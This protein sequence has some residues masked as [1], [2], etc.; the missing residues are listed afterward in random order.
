MNAAASGLDRNRSARIWHRLAAE[1]ESIDPQ[2]RTSMRLPEKQPLTLSQVPTSHLRHLAAASGLDSVGADRPALLKCLNTEL[3]NEVKQQWVIQ[4]AEGLAPGRMKG[5]L[6]SYGSDLY[7]YGGMPHTAFTSANRNLNTTSFAYPDGQTIF[8]RL[9]SSSGNW[10]SVSCE[11]AVPESKTRIHAGH[12][13]VV[14]GDTLFL[15]GNLQSPDPNERPVLPTV[16]VMCHFHFPT[17]KWTRLRLR[18]APEICHYPLLAA[19][20]DQLV[21]FGGQTALYENIGPHDALWTFDMK[22]C[23]WQKR[24]AT[25]DLPEPHLAHALA[26]VNSKAYALV[27]DP[28]GTRRLE[29]Y[30]LDLETWVWR[31]VPPLGTQPSCRR[32]ASAVVAQGQW[33]LYGGCWTG[34][35]YNTLHVFD[36]EKL[37]WSNPKLGG[38]NPLP[39]YYHMATSHKQAMVVLGGLD[40][41]RPEYERLHQVDTVQCIWQ[42][43]APHS[44]DFEDI[45][46]MNLQL[47]SSM[48]TMHQQ[49]EFSD[50]T[51]VVEGQTLRAHRAVLAAASPVF[52][53]MFRSK[54]QEGKSQSIVMNDVA[55]STV[56]MLLQYVYGCLKPELTLAEA[57]AMFEASDMYALTGLHQQCTRL[58]KAL[59]SFDNVFDLAEL[60]Q[61]H[62]CP[63]LLQAC[64]QYVDSLQELEGIVGSDVCSQMRNDTRLRDL[65]HYSQ[66]RKERA[67]MHRQHSANCPSIA[68]SPRHF[69]STD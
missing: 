6:L 34:E 56:E 2:C 58:L 12:A 59:I 60:A 53:C 17:Q 66:H 16:I 9:N 62:D 15:V 67:F 50:A 61:L 49:M 20:K 19:C 14:W 46:I 51:I 44:R 57:V 35:A 64:L 68:E 22:A 45:S 5:L 4:D 8:M 42:Q 52:A 41:M 54:M 27:N 21:L 28:E 36:F 10:D 1:T 30:E 65:Y 43:P 29:V 39:R 32:A 13:G 63:A 47:G 69:R 11:G 26:V 7:L 18:H 31:R 40:Y 37:A 24:H 3:S 48:Q 23:T 38:S 55:A 33:L 25:G